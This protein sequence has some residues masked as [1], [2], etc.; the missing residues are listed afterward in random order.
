MVPKTGGKQVAAGQANRISTRLQARRWC[1][2]VNT[3]TV[4][5]CHASLHTLDFMLESM[6]MSK[7]LTPPTGLQMGR[8]GALSGGRTTRHML[9]L[10]LMGAIRQY[11]LGYKKMPIEKL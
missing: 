11:V 7:P 8:R 1:S 3:K 10:C 9:T 5:P 6:P 2:E 4:H